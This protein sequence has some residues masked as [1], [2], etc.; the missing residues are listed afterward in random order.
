M[1]FSLK[2]KKKLEAGNVED[3]EVKDAPQ[4]DDINSLLSQLAEVNEELA[5]NIKEIEINTLQV[6][7]DRN[8]NQGYGES[9]AIMGVQG[10]S[11]QVVHKAE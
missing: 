4:P 2:L 10:A 11:F 8:K 1:D 5:K 9:Y 7:V 3:V 6:M